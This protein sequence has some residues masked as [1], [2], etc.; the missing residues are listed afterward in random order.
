MCTSADTIQSSGAPLPE[1]KAQAVD[2]VEDTE[3]TPEHNDTST[4]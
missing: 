3:R 1:L 2:K 4:T